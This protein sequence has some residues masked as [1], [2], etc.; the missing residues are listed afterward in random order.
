MEWPSRGSGASPEIS[1]FDQINVSVSKTY[2]SLSLL[3]SSPTPPK[4]NSLEKRRA[5]ACPFLGDGASPVV[6][7]N[8]HTIKFTCSVVPSPS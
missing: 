7:A 4:R 1:G 2:K 3:L 6:S 8:D 5:V